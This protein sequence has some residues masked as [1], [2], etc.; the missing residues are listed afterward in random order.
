MQLKL[1]LVAFNDLLDGRYKEDE[2]SLLTPEEA[3]LLEA[4]T[5]DVG[6]YFMYDTTE[7]PE[8]ILKEDSAVL[9]IPFNGAKMVRYTLQN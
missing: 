2:E 5:I 8:A 7:H 6:G 4:Q 1:S 3:Q 9:Y